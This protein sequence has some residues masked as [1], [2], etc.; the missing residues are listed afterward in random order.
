M[1]FSASVLLILSLLMATASEAAAKT[2]WRTYARRPDTWYRS[3][4]AKKLGD[5]ILAH[6]SESGSWPKNVDTAAEPLPGNRSEI[7]GTFDNGATLNEMRFLSRLVTAREGTDMDDT[8]FR[9]GFLGGID[10]ILEAQYPTG[11]WPQRSPPGTGYHRHITF[12]DHAMVGL[13]RFLRE[14]ATR[15]EYDFVDPPRRQRSATSFDRGI[16]CILRC[17]VIVDGK[18]T[19]WCAQH[20][21][22]TLEPR[23]ARTYELV[24]LSGAE[25]SEIVRLLMSLEMPNTEVTAAIE[26]AIAWYK[27]AQLRGIKIVQEPDLKAPKGVNKVV[28]ADPDAPPLWARFHEIGTNKPIFCDRDGVARDKLAD[29]SYERR[30]GYGWLG[31]WGSPLLETE[32]PAWKAKWM[33]P[34]NQ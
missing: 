29:I 6:Q 15:D 20:D 33:S 8:P 4:E 23:P 34:P 3:P 5:Y 1:K 7:I 18:R 10:H 21:A 13:L 14:V 22:L 16:E 26:G 9:D 25:S 2:P 11:G 12:N 27:A 30:N 32:Y 24:S 17:Q 31:S 28:I 19:V